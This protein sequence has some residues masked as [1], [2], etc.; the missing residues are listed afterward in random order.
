MEPAIKII[1]KKLEETGMDKTEIS[2]LLARFLGEEAEKYVKMQKDMDEFLESKR[3][4][5]ITH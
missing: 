2:Y 5:I 3:K 1:C 4:N